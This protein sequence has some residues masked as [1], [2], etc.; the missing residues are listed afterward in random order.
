M[1]KYTDMVDM[2][3]KT[4]IVTGGLSGAGRAISEVFIESGADMILTYNHSSA[5]AEEMFSSHPDSRISCYHLD[6]SDIGSIE[7]FSDELKRSG[8]TVDCLINNAG[9]YPAKAIDEITPDEWDDMMQTN[10]RGVF[11]LCKCLKPLMAGTSDDKD[12]SYSSIINISSINADNPARA[13]AHYGASKAAVEMLTRSL[14]QAYGSD[15]IRVNCIAPGLI[16]KPGQDEFIPGWTDSYKERSPLH[17]LVMP[18]EIGKT[19]LFLASGLASALTG[20]TITVDCGI[21]LAPCFYNEI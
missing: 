19:C 21:T 16:Y 2:T 18:E 17:K 5:A 11:F 13:L 1:S 14:A 7:E 20:Q 10:A 4:V 9:I 3:G 12:Q 8:I 15:N 6:Q